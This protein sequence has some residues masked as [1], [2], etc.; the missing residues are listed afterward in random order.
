MG[1][2][3]RELRNF[4]LLDHDQQREAMQRLAAA[5][6]SDHGIAAATGLSA[7]MVRAILDEHRTR[8]A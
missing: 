6:M 5:D 4:L 8:A 3:E 2:R 1:H 7:E